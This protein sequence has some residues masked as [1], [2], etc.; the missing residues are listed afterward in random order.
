[1]KPKPGCEEE[2]EEAA[3]TN[4]GLPTVESGV[5]LLLSP[6]YPNKMA[7]AICTRTTNAAG[8]AGESS[9]PSSSGARINAVE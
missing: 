5:D 1:L 4:G 2:K 6:P 7:A 8:V 3:P 9:P